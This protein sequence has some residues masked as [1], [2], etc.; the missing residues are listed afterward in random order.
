M[1]AGRP[2]LS[3]LLVSC[4]LPLPGCR[5]PL[6]PPHQ[7]DPMAV[8]EV[9]V[10]RSLAAEGRLAEAQEHYALAVST[11]S[12]YVEAWLDLANSSL[13]L[14]DIGRAELACRKALAAE[15]SNAAGRYALGTILLREG[16]LQEAVST[17]REVT[18]ESPDNVPA[19]IA[20]ANSLLALG[21][22]DAAAAEY[23]RAAVAD[24]GLAEA[25]IGKGDIA[26]RRGDVQAA[27]AAYRDAVSLA[28]RSSI[29]HH[30]LGTAY[31]RTG[32]LGEAVLE[33]EKSVQIDSTD[34]A[35][36][37]RIGVVLGRLGRNEEAQIHISASAR[38]RERLER[39][40]SSEEVVSRAPEDPAARR[41]L[42][43]TCV[44]LDLPRE[45]ERH[46]RIA[47]RLAP[48]DPQTH[49]DL[50]CL[51]F[52]RHRLTEATSEFKQVLSLAPDS[53]DTGPIN[54]L[55]HFNLGVACIL[56][57]AVDEAQS[58]LLTAAEREPD[59]PPVSFTI[60]ALHK[61]TGRL[62]ESRK[63]FDRFLELTGRTAQDSVAVAGAEENL[64]V[65]GEIFAP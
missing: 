24:P 64:Q 6:P 15:P 38:Q 50:G 62:A 20:L 28:P 46:Y 47:L 25:C 30:R 18:R 49:L 56:Q 63:S 32:S 3:L 60:G 26:E 53:T 54:T 37:Y 65:Y 48:D 13:C 19:T 12:L 42:A 16:R 40:R 35:I 55:A 52:G 10:G 43:R 7:P 23:D 22:V 4:A 45:G 9:R 5:Q 17:F 39:I 14:L 57:G 1:K 27:L 33:L 21:E 34:P 58:E 36:R 8:R 11:D 29:A 59:W 41:A 51:L 44:D 2:W 31:F 61:Q